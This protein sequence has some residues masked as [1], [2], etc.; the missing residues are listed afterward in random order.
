MTTVRVNLSER[1]YDIHLG[2]VAGLGAF[3]RTVSPGNVAFVVGDHN[4]ATHAA[5]VGE[6]LVDTSL[7][8]AGSRF[9]FKIRSTLMTWCVSK[10]AP[11][12]A[13]C[14]AFLPQASQ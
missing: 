9:S 10:C 1:S 11:T 5:T 6:S 14:L 12:C 7:I 8:K 4:T 13:S 2:P 3:A